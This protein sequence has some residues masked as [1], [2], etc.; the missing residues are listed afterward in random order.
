MS[1]F[2]AVLSFL[3]RN[4]VAHHVVPVTDASSLDARRWLRPVLLQ[5]GAGYVLA[6]VPRDDFLDV[7]ALNTTLQRELQ[8]VFAEQRAEFLEPRGGAELFPFGALYNVTTV[9]QNDIPAEG[10]LGVVDSGN[11]NR[12]QLDAAALRGLQHQPVEAKIAIRV[13]PELVRE[14]MERHAFA[15][16]RIESM[17]GDVEGLPAMPEMSTRIL[18]VTG[19][20]DSDANDLARVIEVDPSLSAQIISYATSAFYGYRGDI[21][22]VRDAISRVL[23]FDLVANIALGISI[24]T[25][26]RVSPDGPIGLSA[27]WRHAVYT[28]AL[29]E[30]ISKAVPRDR[31]VRSG[32]AYLSG[33]LHDF[34]FLLLGHLM[35]DAF[36]ALNG[37]I[38]ANPTIEVTVLE[39][40]VVGCRHTDIGDKL[41]QQWKIHDEAVLAARHHHNAEYRDEF[42]AY[43]Q[44]VLVAEHLLHEHGVV[45]DSD[46]NP[47]PETT[48]A[49]LGLTPETVDKAALPVIDACAGLDTLAQM[50]GNAA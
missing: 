19:D 17:L 2:N 21:T 26:F 22:S 33:L 50:L 49:L 24:G 37:A 14:R 18:Q 4:S 9:I 12:I 43:A 40:L 36:K 41:L 20:S 23:G 42:A 46:W 13:T 39:D 3:E 35:P 34:G 10:P 29:A 6:V 16:K 48:L 47:V 7:A 32:M 38:A 25:S 30:R 11:V 45:S 44:L 28:S 5:D 15:R 1:S 8:P 31:Q 27:F